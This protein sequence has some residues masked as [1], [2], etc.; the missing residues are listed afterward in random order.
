MYKKRRYPRRPSR[1]G[2][3]PDVL[4]LSICRSLD[5]IQR[6]PGADIIDCLHPVCTAQALCFGGKFPEESHALSATALS[7][8]GVRG[9]SVRG[10]QFDLSGYVS[11]WLPQGPPATSPL[12]LNH[13]VRVD[14]YMAIVKT[15][16]DVLT[17]QGTG[18]ITPTWPRVPNII[19]SGTELVMAVQNRPLHDPD[20]EIFWRGLETAIG[21]NCQECPAQLG[22]DCPALSLAGVLSRPTLGSIASQAEARLYNTRHVKLR[23]GRFLK[24]NEAIF[25]V[26]NYVA[27]FLPENA[28]IAWTTSLYG[29]AL[30][31]VAK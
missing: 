19:V 22:E 31:R 14:H 3:K 13:S 15:E 18:V 6:D 8:E 26:H 29:N 24:E 21:G 20:V 4:S 11:C 17:A 2:R 9:A 27:E 1:K 5:L 30:V 28:V 7:E 16:Y 25:L 10:M 12:D 23:T